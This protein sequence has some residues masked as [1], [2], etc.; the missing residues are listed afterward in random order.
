MTTYIHQKNI[1]REYILKTFG[2]G[3]FERNNKGWLNCIEYIFTNFN[4]V[5]QFSPLFFGMIWTIIPEN[6]LIK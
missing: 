2:Q 4:A 6:D 1:Y 5:I 3:I